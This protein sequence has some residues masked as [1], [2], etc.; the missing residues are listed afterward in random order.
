MSVYILLG[1]LASRLIHLVLTTA[2]WRKFYYIYLF[3]YEVMEAHMKSCRWEEPEF[4]FK[5]SGSYHYPML[6]VNYNIICDYLLT[7]ELIK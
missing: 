1:S 6:P 3:K 2:L 5:L 7:S 4:E